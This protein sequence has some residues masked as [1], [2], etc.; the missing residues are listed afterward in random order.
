MKEMKDSHHHHH[1]HLCFTFAVSGRNSELLIT[2]VES[3]VVVVVV[4]MADTVRKV[5]EGERKRV[6]WYIVIETRGMRLVM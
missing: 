4:W 6:Y 1:H 5:M 2:R 3:I